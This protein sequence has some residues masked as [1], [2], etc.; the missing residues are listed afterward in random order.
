MQLSFSVGSAIVFNGLAQEY[1][2][3]ESRTRNGIRMVFSRPSVQVN[4]QGP[5]SIRNKHNP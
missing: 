2:Y 4:E 5:Y 1:G 3:I